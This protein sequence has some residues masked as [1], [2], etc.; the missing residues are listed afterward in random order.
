MPRENLKGEIKMYLVVNKVPYQGNNIGQFETLKE[1]KAY[2]KER[3]EFYKKYNMKINIEIYSVYKI[4][5]V[6][7]TKTL[8]DE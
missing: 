4:S 6:I 5:K 2:L 1:V 7:D 8:I 3:Q